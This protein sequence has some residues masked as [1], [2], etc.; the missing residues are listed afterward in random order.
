MEMPCRLCLI[1]PICS[2]RSR[3]LIKELRG[4]YPS[5]VLLTTLP[6]ECHYIRKYLG[7]DDLKYTRTSMNKLLKVMGV[8]KLE[9]ERKKRITKMKITVHK[10]DTT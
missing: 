9:Q 1:F 10:G 6:G 8:W 7:I 5:T 4:L 3:L 2:N